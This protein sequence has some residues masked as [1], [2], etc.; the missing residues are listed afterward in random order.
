MS[1]QSENIL[2]ASLCANTTISC[3]VAAEYQLQD[4]NKRKREWVKKWR[5]TRAVCGNIQTLLK[6]Y[7]LSSDRDS[8]KSF[9]RMDEDCFR[10]ILSYIENDISRE[11]THL[12]EAIPPAEKLAAT[13]RYLATGENFKEL[14]ENTK[15]SPTYLQFSII[16]VC[17]AIYRRMSNEFLKVKLKHLY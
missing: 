15:L 1:D 3:L 12:R 17:E 8:Y 4:K 9:L 13:L 10:R 6:E 14:A 7:T 5:K 16:E 11:D 2:I